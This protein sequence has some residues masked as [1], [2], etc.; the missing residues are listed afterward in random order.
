MIRRSKLIK[1]PKVLLGKL[2]SE[3][4]IHIGYLMKNFEY[5][6]NL[7]EV[8]ERIL[9]KTKEVFRKFI[10]ARTDL[11]EAY[12]DFVDQATLIDDI[13]VDVISFESYQFKVQTHGGYSD[14]K[15]YTD[16]IYEKQKKFLERMEVFFRVPDVQRYLSLPDPYL[17]SKKDI[18]S[19]KIILKSSDFAGLPY[20][21]KEDLELLDKVGYTVELVTVEEKDEPVE[22]GLCAFFKERKKFVIYL[23]VSNE[24]FREHIE[25]TMS[26]MEKTLEHELTHLMQ[27]LMRDLLLVKTW[28]LG[29]KRVRVKENDKTTWEDLN[30]EYKSQLRDISNRM[31]SLDI[32]FSSYDRYL[33][34]IEKNM[35]YLP[36]L[37]SLKA[38]S[39]KK[40]DLALK[41]IYK[42][43]H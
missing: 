23:Y 21:K 10:N 6:A 19:K 42:E 17:V 28:G 25:Y 13:K 14:L 3:L 12:D 24:M 8:D 27:Y 18:I 2:L 9:E 11:K 7:T 36:F 22:D 15:K 40:Y 39:Q 41:E 35:L 43:H 30:I 34:D 20:L 1:L 4:D 16:S 31:L 29:K 5:V 32:D 26:E 38:V 37:S 33:K